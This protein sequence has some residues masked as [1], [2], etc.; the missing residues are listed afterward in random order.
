MVHAIAEVNRVLALGG[1]LIDA[2]PVGTKFDV[3][4]CENSRCL[5]LGS[6]DR[7]NVKVRSDEE[8]NS[9]LGYGVRHGWLIPESTEWITSFYYGDDPSEDIGP[10]EIPEPECAQI[11]KLLKGP[12]TRLRAR[13]NSTVAIYRKPVTP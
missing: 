2:R 1:T 3:E 12:G 9:A 8:C 5:N 11:R 10:V 13:Y 6:F 7:S 4:L